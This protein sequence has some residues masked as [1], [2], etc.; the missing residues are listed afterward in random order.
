MAERHSRLGLRNEAPRPAR[1]G[2]RLAAVLTALLTLA[3]FAGILIALSPDRPVRERAA[4]GN[5]AAAMMPANERY[6]YGGAEFGRFVN[7]SRGG[8]P[9]GAETF[10]RWMDAQLPR[11]KAAG[12]PPSSW[13]GW[14]DD[15]RRALE[16]IRDPGARANAERDVSATV[17]RR[18]KLAIPRFSLDRGFEFRYTVQHLSLIH[19]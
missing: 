19:I 17:H 6:P 18:V 8:W 15:K 9:G 1:K 14:M 11:T 3:A 12:P 4:R 10:Y 16:G 5:A 7:A 13:P 2:P